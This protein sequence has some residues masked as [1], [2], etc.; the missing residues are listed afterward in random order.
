MEE[1][2]QD[3]KVRLLEETERRGL[4]PKNPETHGHLKDCY[5]KGL[6]ERGLFLGLPRHGAPALCGDRLGPYACI[7]EP[8]GLESL[9]YGPTNAWLHTT[10]TRADLALEEAL[11]PWQRFA[12]AVALP[13]MVAG[14]KRLWTERDPACRLS[15]DTIW[16]PYRPLAVL[17]TFRYHQEIFTLQARGNQSHGDLVAEISLLWRE[18]LV[19]DH[20]RRKA[21][22]RCGCKFCVEMAN[23]AWFGP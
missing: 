13:A 20:A 4:P 10:E 1:S 6:D 15:W 22:P 23:P 2:D 17:F 19:R 5:G 12:E 21:C 7:L 11:T 8:H 3:Y 14:I 9:H 18:A 16:P